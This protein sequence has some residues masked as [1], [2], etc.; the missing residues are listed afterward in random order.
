MAAVDDDAAD[1]DDEEAVVVEVS[2]ARRGRRS[3]R[4]KHLRQNQDWIGACAAAGRARAA[5]LPAFVYVIHSERNDMVYVGE[6]TD[7]NEDSIAKAHDRGTRRYTKGKGPWQVKLLV[8][9]FPTTV[10]A[11]RFE[12]FVKDKGR[13]RGLNPKIR[14]AQ[15][16]LQAG[17]LEA[18]KRGPQDLVA[19]VAAIGLTHFV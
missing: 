6:T 8:G 11:K 15:A 14:A 3:P 16:G 7:S 4:R 18:A 12:R 9:P 1:T 17:A 5:A 10:A 2:C 13:D 19:V